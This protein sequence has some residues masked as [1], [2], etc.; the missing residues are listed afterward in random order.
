M[1]EQQIAGASASVASLDHDL[2]PIHVIDGLFTSDFVTELSDVL[3]GLPYT[4]NRWVTPETDDVLLFKAELQP[5]VLLS[6]LPLELESGEAGPE[7]RVN[8]A[9]SRLVLAVG[10]CSAE[11]YPGS[12]RRLCRAYANAVPFGADL[13]KHVDATSEGALT[14]VYFANASW[15]DEWRGE[16]ILCDSD[17]ESLYAVDFRP[18][19]LVMF[20]GRV[21]HRA[22]APSRSCYVNRLTVVFKFDG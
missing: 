12:N 5:N 19:R 21:A 17:A 16:L 18:G 15:R 4:C 2:G 3:Q 14:A 13:D 11:L 6:G 1:P 9:L 10:E 22:C 20:P 7:S 8:R